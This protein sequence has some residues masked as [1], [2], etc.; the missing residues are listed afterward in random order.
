MKNLKSLAATATSAAVIGGT[1][2]GAMEFIGWPPYAARADFEEV[3]EQVYANSLAGLYIQLEN[4][5]K[6][7]DRDRILRLCWAIQQQTGQKPAGC[8]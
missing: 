2:V 6:A 5:I 8:P 4:A 1:L 7:G 3:K